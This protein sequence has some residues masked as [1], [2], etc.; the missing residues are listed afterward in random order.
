MHCSCAL[1]TALPGFRIIFDDDLAQYDHERQLPSGFLM[2]KKIEFCFSR[3]YINDHVASLENMSTK[4]R[5]LDSS[6]GRPGLM[7]DL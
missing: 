1:L 4:H 3:F 6:G 7:L 2:T 5:V